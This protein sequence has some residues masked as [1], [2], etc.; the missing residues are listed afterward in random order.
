MEFRWME[1]P[2]AVEKLNPLIERRGWALLNPNTSR[3][4]V[5]L[6]G[7][8]IKGYMV[9]QLFPMLGPTE[10]LTEEGGM[11]LRGLLSRMGNFMEETNAR[12][13]MVVVENPKIGELC[14]RFGMKELEMPVYVG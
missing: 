8:E 12:G 9:L 1:G 2:E 5:A 11:V 4:I 6:E 10:T 13:Y 14:E 7:D 3:A